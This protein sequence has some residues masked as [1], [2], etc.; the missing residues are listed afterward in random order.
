VREGTQGVS[1]LGQR[2]VAR[3]VVIYKGVVDA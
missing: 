1:A 3:V 2:G